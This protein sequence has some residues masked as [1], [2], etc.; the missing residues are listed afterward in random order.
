MRHRRH[1]W[2][3]RHAPHLRQGLSRRNGRRLQPIRRR[4]LVADVEPK[5][6]R[7]TLTNARQRRRFG[8]VP[9]PAL[10]SGYGWRL[11]F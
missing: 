1:E 9:L 2:R 10:F 3:H 11:R 5:S 7:R 8:F 6:A 4:H